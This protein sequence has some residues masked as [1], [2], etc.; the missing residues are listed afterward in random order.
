[1]IIQKKSK[2]TIKTSE[3]TLWNW[4]KCSVFDIP[5][6]N[7][8]IKKE[9]LIETN[10]DWRWVRSERLESKGPDKEL[11][12]KTKIEWDKNNKKMG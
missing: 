7:E 2:K 4:W 6:K 11:L 3:K 5:L 10:N 9:W 12:L 8:R 1:M